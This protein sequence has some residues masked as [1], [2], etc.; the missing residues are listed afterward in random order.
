MKYLILFTCIV[1]QCIF[2]DQFYEA[3]VAID[4]TPIQVIVKNFD[5]PITIENYQVEKTRLNEVWLRAWE[6]YHR[7]DLFSHPSERL[8]LFSKGQIDAFNMNEEALEM[9]KN[10]F[11]VFKSKYPRNVILYQIYAKKG[12]EEYYLAFF[13]TYISTNNEI[14]RSELPSRNRYK[15][16]D[17]VWKNDNAPGMKFIDWLDGSSLEKVLERL[18]NGPSQEARIY[19]PTAAGNGELELTGFGPN[20]KPISAPRLINIDEVPRAILAKPRAP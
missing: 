2:A 10:E 19:G 20:I 18:K 3:E 9:A 4:D 6:A 14:I 5:P 8:K 12:I 13:T 15:K 16:E 7:E 1:F 17:G 11:I